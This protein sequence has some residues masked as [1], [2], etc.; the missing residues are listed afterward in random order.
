MKRTKKQKIQASI[1]HVNTQSAYSFNKSYNE[2]SKKNDPI[3]MAKTSNLASIKKELLKSLITATLILTALL[4]IYWV[5][6]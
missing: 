6:N 5:Q 3:F 1:R 2:K 4:V